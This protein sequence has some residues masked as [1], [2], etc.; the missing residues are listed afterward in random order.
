MA[1]YEL[2]ETA[3]RRLEDIYRY[4]MVTFGLQTAGR[5]L[6]A[7][8][9]AFGLLV[10]NPQIG[11]DHGW[12]KPGYRRLVHESHVIY[13]RPLETGVLIVEILH[14]AQDPARHFEEET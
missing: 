9:Q 13:Y 5:Y 2:T 7:L 14:K 1:G 11:T 10:E 4:S 6:E 12:I 3:E 8:H